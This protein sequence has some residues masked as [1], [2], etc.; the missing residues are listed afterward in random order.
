M[1]APREVRQKVQDKRRA[2]AD[3]L[4]G[5]LHES[6]KVIVDIEHLLVL[7]QGLRGLAG[8]WLGGSETRDVRN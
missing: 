7:S 6:V 3:Y 4:L 2:N 5:V 1:V 8:R